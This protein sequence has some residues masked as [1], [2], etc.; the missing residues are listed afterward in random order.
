M[1]FPGGGEER[2]EG[3][4]RDLFL[5]S[6]GPLLAAVCP[7]PPFSEQ[8]DAQRGHVPLFC[9]ILLETRPET[10]VVTNVPGM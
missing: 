8:T 6:S 10:E 3:G 2:L 5:A 7:L 4:T 9:V 1:G